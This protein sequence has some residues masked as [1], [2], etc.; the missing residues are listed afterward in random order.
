MKNFFKSYRLALI[1]IGLTF[2]LLFFLIL[3]TFNKNTFDDNIGLLLTMIFFV[4]YTVSSIRYGLAYTNNITADW[5]VNDRLKDIL[6]I[7]WQSAAH[8]ILGIVILDYVYIYLKND[9]YCIILL[10]LT[11]V[12]AITD[13]LIRYKKIK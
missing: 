13:F 1:E 3:T 2:T 11:I 6:N 4:I 5:K 7:L 9:L 8:L 10:L 12:T